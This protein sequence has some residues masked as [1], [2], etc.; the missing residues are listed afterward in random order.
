M[1]APAGLTGLLAAAVVLFGSALF[2]GLGRGAQAVASPAASLAK[3]PQLSRLYLG[4]GTLT[5]GEEVSGIPSDTGLGAFSIG[6]FYPR[7]VVQV[8]VEEGPFL[9]STGRVTSCSSTYGESFIEFH[10]TS[11]GPKPGPSGSGT[12]VYIRVLPQPELMLKPTSGNGAL[13]ILDDQESAAALA[14]PLGDGIEVGHVG[15]SAI[16]VQ[17]LE[18]DLNRDCVVNVIDEQSISFR[19][20]AHEG[21]L[22]YYPFYDL[23]PPLGDGD[24]DIK[25][26]QFVFGRDGRTCEG[27]GP[28]PTPTPT[29]T[30]TTTATTTPAG[31]STATRTATATRTPVP[32]STPT[33]TATA[34]TKKT[35]T[36]VGTPTPTGTA[37]ATSTPTAVGTRTPIATATATRTPVVKK[38][39]T[40]TAIG[41]TTPIATSMPIV[42]GTLAPTA[43]AVATST[44]IVIGT[45]TPAAT[46][47]PTVTAAGTA[48]PIGTAQTPTPT[49][50]GTPSA[51]PVATATPPTSVGPISVTPVPQEPLPTET[52][53]AG[54]LP[55]VTPRARVLPPTGSGPAEGWTAQTTVAA[56]IL[57]GVGLALLLLSLFRRPS[58]RKP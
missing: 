12:L 1:G 57:A 51:A 29:A 31:T 5:I 42:V 27:P 50:A 15:D 47:T 22:F 8:T 3:D 56:G 48:T 32:T 55:A 2:L 4:G 58:G 18:G 10:C 44:P 23:Q 14:D 16:I 39:P 40:P 25:D 7:D 24:I 49:G 28:T 26:L 30:A 33:P 17:A 52:R 13:A 9:R 41:T 20:Q 46:S 19:Y 36:P 38:T 34:V 6:F 21:S 43:T 54:V 11:S 37:A 53:A 35:P 45:L